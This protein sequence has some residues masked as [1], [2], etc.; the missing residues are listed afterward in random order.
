MAFCN[1]ATIVC[2]NHDCS[3]VLNAAVLITADRAWV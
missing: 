1:V 3:H 2:F